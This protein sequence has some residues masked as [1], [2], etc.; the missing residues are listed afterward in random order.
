ML[1]PYTYVSHRME[2]MQAYIA[3]GALQP[4]SITIATYALCGF[5]NFTNIA[6]LI[7]GIGSIA[8]ER[9]KEVAAMS[10]KAL[11]AGVIASFMTAAIAGMLV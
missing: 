7:G 1:F 2:K 9:K 5:A 3:T 10:L 8:P 11:L 4:R 6:I